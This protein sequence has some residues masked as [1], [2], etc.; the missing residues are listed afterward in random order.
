MHLFSAPGFGVLQNRYRLTLYRSSTDQL[1]LGHNQQAPFRG[2]RVQGSLHRISF[3]S[4]IS[5]MSSDS[6]HDSHIQPL[7]FKGEIMDF[8][9]GMEVDHRKR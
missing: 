3:T 5:N 8:D 4:L 9:I 7:Q 1:D 2:I 6:S